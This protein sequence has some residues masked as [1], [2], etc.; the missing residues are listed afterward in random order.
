MG[1][2]DFFVLLGCTAFASNKSIR[3][4]KHR[5]TMVV[6]AIETQSRQQILLRNEKRVSRVYAFFRKHA[7]RARFRESVCGT[8]KTCMRVFFRFPDPFSHSKRKRAAPKKKNAFKAGHA[9]G[10]G[11]FLTLSGLARP[12][13]CAESVFSKKRIHS[14]VFS[15]N[16]TDGVISKSF[17]A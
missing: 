16:T 4:N 17:G 6:G 2:G 7:F 14:S 15:A 10:S 5:T 13:A 1:V 11:F 3:I 8:K 12:K 9:S